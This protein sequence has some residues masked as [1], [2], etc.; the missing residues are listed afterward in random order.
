MTKCVKQF[1]L[2]IANNRRFECSVFSVQEGDKDAKLKGYIELS[3]YSSYRNCYK[4]CIYMLNGQEN[5]LEKHLS[6]R[7]MRTVA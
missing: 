4:E 3:G 1:Q 7:S 5:S 6:V 2:G